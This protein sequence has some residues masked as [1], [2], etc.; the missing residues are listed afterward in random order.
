M[1][2]ATIEDGVERRELA[3]RRSDGI[4]VSLL[5]SR[6][7]KSLSVVVLDQGSGASFELVVENGTEALDVFRHPFAYAAW[8]GVD[9]GIPGES[10]AA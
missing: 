10:V 6:P 8:R 4:D 5:W 1:S 3:H 9:H 7:A 2:S